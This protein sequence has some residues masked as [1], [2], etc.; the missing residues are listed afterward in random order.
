MTLPKKYRQALGV[1]NGGSVIADVSSDGI[2]LHPAVAFPIE[3]YSDERIR[4]F[5][6]ADQELSRALN[7]E[8]S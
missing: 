2:T 1:V 6:T 7:A 8:N 5:D 4:E 3:I